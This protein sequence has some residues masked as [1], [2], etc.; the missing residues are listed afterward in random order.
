MSQADE[1]HNCEIVQ[2]SNCCPTHRSPQVWP[3]TI[4]IRLQISK[5]YGK[6][7]DQMIES[8]W[9]LKGILKK[10]LLHEFYM[11]RLKCSKNN[12]LFA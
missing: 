9:Q 3:Q 1:C 12:G 6:D 10:L 8:L 2:S 7:F 11:K 5:Q 4:V